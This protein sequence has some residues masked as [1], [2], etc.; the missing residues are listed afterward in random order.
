M[1]DYNT[2]YITIVARVNSK[3][4]AIHN[5]LSPAS[6][7]IYCIVDKD[8]HLSIRIIRQTEVKRL[9]SIY[10]FYLYSQVQTDKKKY[11]IKKDII[12]LVFYG[13]ISKI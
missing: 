9:M 13:Y 5:I 4:T 7:F 1:A 10:H 8:F 6:H 11:N 2:C 12:E 3:V